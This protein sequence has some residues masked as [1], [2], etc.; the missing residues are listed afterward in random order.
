MI[1]RLSSEV[2]DRR[3][4]VSVSDEVVEDTNLAAK[5]KGE[6]HRHLTPVLA[7]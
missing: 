7:T 2:F 3:A 4:S 5:S 6:Q 1:R